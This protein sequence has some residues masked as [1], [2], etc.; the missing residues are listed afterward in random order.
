[1]LGDKNA[2]VR[3][4][5]RDW[6][7]GMTQQQLMHTSPSEFDGYLEQKGVTGLNEEQKEHVVL[8]VSASL[9]WANQGLAG[10]LADVWARFFG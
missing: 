8:A 10:E 6:F 5:L 3:R 2:Q 4:L 7:A 9:R 1:M